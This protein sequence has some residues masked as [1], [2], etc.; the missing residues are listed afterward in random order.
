MYNGREVK[1]FWLDEFYGL[2]TELQLSVQLQLIM[3][4]GGQIIRI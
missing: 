4:S 1:Q 2:S 3:Y